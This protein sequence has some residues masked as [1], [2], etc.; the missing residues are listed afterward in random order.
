MAPQTGYV[1]C[2]ETAANATCVVQCASGYT[3]TPTTYLCDGT[4]A[5]PAFVAQG[6]VGQC[7]ED[8]SR[9]AG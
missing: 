3:G 8:A 9:C 7:V 2:G 5:T 1:V 6:A 4:L